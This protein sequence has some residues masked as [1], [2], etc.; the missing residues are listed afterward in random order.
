[1][2]LKESPAPAGY[3]QLSL[4]ILYIKLCLLLWLHFWKTKALLFLIF[5]CVLRNG[6]RPS[7]GNDRRILLNDI[8]LSS[9]G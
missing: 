8:L 6:V 3:D 1:M 9:R 7:F 4:N 2:T 5:F